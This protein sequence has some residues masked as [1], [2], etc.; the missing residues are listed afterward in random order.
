MASRSRALIASTVTVVPG[1]RWYQ[2]LAAMT[3]AA[4]ITTAAPIRMFLRL[5]YAPDRAVRTPA[6]ISTRM[7]YRPRRLQAIGPVRLLYKTPSPI[8]RLTIHQI[9]KRSI[10]PINRPKNVASSIILKNTERLVGLAIDWL[11]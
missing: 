8:D 9:R 4:T 2:T 11:M 10:E 5:I 7:T 3:A 6:M 1:F